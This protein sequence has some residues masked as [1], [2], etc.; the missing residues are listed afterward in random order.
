VPSEHVPAAA[1]G[2]GAAPAF[3][4]SPPPW[5]SPAPVPPTSPSPYAPQGYAPSP[6][7]SHL[8][9]LNAPPPSYGQGH[10]LPPGYAPPAASYSPV[11]APQA[12]RSNLPLFAAAGCGLLLVLGVVGAVALVAI[13]KSGEPSVSAGPPG[14]ETGDG[15]AITL[16]TSLPTS[17]PIA[18]TDDDFDPKNFDVSGFLAQAEKIAHR[19]LP[20]AKLVGMDITGVNPKGIVNFDLGSGT[21]ALYRFRSP[22]RSVPPADFPKNASFE[23]NCVAYVMVQKS[24]VTSF[25]TDRMACDIPFTGNPS[26]SVEKLWLRAAK[27]GAPKDNVIGNLGFNGQM[28]QDGKLRW[29]MS[30][31]PDFSAVLPDGC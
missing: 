15:P 13:G 30:V 7:P 8:P 21:M 26:C 5:T 9:N 28:M 14:T 22:S 6:A 18:Q 27:Q 20:D 25:V 12:A 11:P 2:Y 4:P 31:A 24:G 3:A 10:G 16:P 17:S 29:Y 19:H 23:S 1:A